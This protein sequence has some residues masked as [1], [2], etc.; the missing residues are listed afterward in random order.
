[1]FEMA[2]ARK[3]TLTSLFNLFLNDKAGSKKLLC[4][5]LKEVYA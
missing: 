2:L 4:T 5:Y 1:M 3:V